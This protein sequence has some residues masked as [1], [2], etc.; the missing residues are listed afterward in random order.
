MLKEPIEVVYGT[1]IESIGQPTDIAANLKANGSVNFEAE[2]PIPRQ[3]AASTKNASSAAMIVD[4]SN[5][6]TDKIV[7]AVTAFTEEVSQKSDQ[8]K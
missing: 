5:E 2:T 3:S 4:Q 1:L 6:I 7:P 8:N